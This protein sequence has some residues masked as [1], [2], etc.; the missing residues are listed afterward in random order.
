MCTV[1]VNVVLGPG[2]FD[3]YIEEYQNLVVQN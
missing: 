2:D 3:L 1:G